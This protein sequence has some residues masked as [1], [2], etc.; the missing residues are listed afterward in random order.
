VEWY[1]RVPAELIGTGPMSYKQSPNVQCLTCG[2]VAAPNVKAEVVRRS[3][4][5]VLRPSSR[6]SQSAASL[7]SRQRAATDWLLAIDNCLKREATV[8]QRCRSCRILM[9]PG[10]IETGVGL[11]C[12]TCRYAKRGESGVLLVLRPLFGKRGWLKRLI[13]R[14]PKTSLLLLTA[15]VEIS[16]RTNDGSYPKS[17]ALRGIT[18]GWTG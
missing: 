1:L 14:H 17:V 15:E 9:G 3:V 11:L 8:H 4:V 2:R 13:G 5:R 6:S 16:S 12:G 18:K 10:H 7:T